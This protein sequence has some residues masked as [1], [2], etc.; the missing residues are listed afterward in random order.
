M[1]ANLFG[2]LVRLGRAAAGEK[3]VT[4]VPE[5]S[6]TAGRFVS[7]IPNYDDFFEQVAGTLVETHCE[8][9]MPIETSRG[10]W[11][12]KKKCL[13]CGRSEDN[14][15]YRVKSRQAICDEMEYLAGRHRTVRFMVVD[16]AV[17]EKEIA[18]IA[19]HAQKMGYDY[20]V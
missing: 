9:E 8:L 18:H 13:F 16:P 15:K 2:V 20:R 3:P 14:L 17:L 12:Y 6:P 4:V 11:W 7:V 10:C 19:D 1:A 5:V